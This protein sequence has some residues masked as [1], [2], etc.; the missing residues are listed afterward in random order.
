[1]LSQPPFYHDGPPILP[2]S[3]KRSR[4]QQRLLK[5]GKLMVPKTPPK[6]PCME[7]IKKLPISI[8]LKILSSTSNTGT[9]S[10]LSLPPAKTLI[11][12]N[13]RLRQAPDG[14]IVFTCA[15]DTPSI[16]LKSDSEKKLIPPLPHRRASSSK[17][18]CQW[19]QQVIPIVISGL[20]G[21]TFA[22]VLWA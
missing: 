4:F 6:P 13:P 9:Y 7:R 5:Q 14:K 16:L 3:N 19:C 11:I 12:E 17:K 21:F 22:L 18:H 10:I 2:N 8:P 20:V 15:A 1:M